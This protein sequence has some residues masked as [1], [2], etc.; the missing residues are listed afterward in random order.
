[1]KTKSFVLVLLLISYQTV[2]AQFEVGKSYAGPS[3]GLSFLGSTFQ[4]GLNY[5][6]GM[7]L[8]SIGV[9]AP[10]KLGVGGVFRYWG[11]SEDFG[12]G[13][14]SYTDIL[15]GAQGNYHFVVG[16]GKLDPYIGLVLAYDIGSVNWEGVKAIGWTD[17]TSG[18]F[19][20]GLQGGL[21]YFFSPKTALNAR[22]GFGTLSY[23]ALEVGIDF[24]L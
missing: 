20:L 7:S 23:G 2:S 6:Y 21:R 10:G 4:L 22:F 11:Y 15:I 18:G 24:T 3:L 8:E 14:W 16:D 19:W 5:E 13:K 1:M 12:A 9:S 17:R